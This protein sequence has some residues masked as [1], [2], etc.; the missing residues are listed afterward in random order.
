MRF[1]H[2]SPWLDTPIGQKNH[3]AYILFL[4]SLLVGLGTLLYLASGYTKVTCGRGLVLRLVSDSRVALPLATPSQV[5][6]SV[7]NAHRGERV[8]AGE[9]P[10]D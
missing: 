9:K 3:R 6:R 7:A 8:F 2:F 4:I 1:D 5:G 10:G